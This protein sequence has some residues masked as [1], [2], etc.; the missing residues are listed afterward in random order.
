MRVRDTIALALLAGC[1]FTPLADRDAGGGADGPRPIADAAPVPDATVLGPWSTPTPIVLSPANATD[2]DPSLTG[3]RLE[4]YI[5]TSRS[6]GPDIYVA[7]R[8]ATTEPWGT[9][10][11]VPLVSSAQNEATPEVSSDGLTLYFASDRPG[12]AGDLD[13]WVSTRTARTEAW[14][15]PTVVAELSSAVHDAC[16]ATSA[17]QLQ[18]VMTSFRKPPLTWSDIY[19]STRTAPT[20]AWGTPVELDAINTPA[21]DRS[22]FLTADARSLYLDRTVSGASSDLFVA[23]RPSATA[24][25]PA[26]VPISELN[27]SGAEEDPWV[28]PDGR[29]IV[30]WS[31][32]G[33]TGQL[34][35]AT[36]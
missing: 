3:D 36:R 31:D 13:I 8:A 9:P 6:G 24:A 2:D 1:S 25:F 12:G 16:P 15:A 17:S 7:T 19:V 27:T 11:R 5:N 33:A 21:D 26:A 34:W 14:G 18:L 23:T 4:L 30:F 10:E 28:S 32:R 35:E 29:H 20:M 22:P